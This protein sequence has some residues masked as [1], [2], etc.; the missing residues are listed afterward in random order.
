MSNTVAPNLNFPIEELN[1]RIAYIEQNIPY[2]I[3]SCKEI[4]KKLL[5]RETLSDAEEKERLDQADRKFE[6]VLLE[7]IHRKYNLD[8]SLCEQNGNIIGKT[9]FRWVIDAIDGAMNFL[10]GVP[11]YA[12]SIGIQ[13]REANVAGIIILPETRDVYVGVHGSYALKNQNRILV[14]E[15]DSLDRSLIITPFP[16]QKKIN[17]QEIMSELSAFV[18]SGRS[19]RRTGS[20]VVDLCWLAEGKI[21]GIWEKGIQI[22]DFAAASVLIKEAGGKL[23]DFKGDDLFSFPSTMVASNGLVHGQILEV[24]KKTRQEL[25]LN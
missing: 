20:T 2:F 24:L 16:S 25:S 11:L 3:T 21:D 15:I 19:I 1:E 14:S 9:N 8:S 12:I 4:Q 10:R 18:A 7:T 23:S 22:W 5:I 6:Q 13:H 17:L